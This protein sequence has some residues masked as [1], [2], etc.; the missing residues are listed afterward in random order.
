MSSASL[1]KSS[2]MVSCFSGCVRL[3]RDSVCT[4][5]TPPSFL[6]TYIVCRSGWSN[7][8]WNLFATTRNR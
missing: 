5:L 7:P 1:A 4:A 2:T 3:S 8:V 6:S